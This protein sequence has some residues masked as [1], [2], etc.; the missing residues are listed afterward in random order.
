MSP[1]FYAVDDAL[2]AGEFAMLR[3]YC[4][5]LKY[6]DRVG[7]DGATYQ[8]I[9][10][11]VPETIVEQMTCLLSWLVGYRAVIKICAFRLSVLGTVPPQWAHSDMEVARYAS[12]L[13]INPGMG[14]TAL[15]KHKETGLFTHPK[16]EYELTILHRDQNDMEKWAVTSKVDCAPNR[17]LVIRSGL[18][19]AALPFHGFGSGPADGRLILWTFFD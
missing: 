15:L 5:L 11:E 12:F 8:G 6:H 10:D 1:Y 9:S 18:I 4:Q 17:A 7:P 13:Y 2:P 14:G 3:E 16:D 19:H